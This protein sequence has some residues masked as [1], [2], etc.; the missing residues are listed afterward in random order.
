MNLPSCPDPELLATCAEGRLH[1]DERENVLRHI[2]SCHDCHAVF[3]ETL[4]LLDEPTLA[5]VPE[6]RLA[7]EAPPPAATRPAPPENVIPY[8]PRRWRR[9]ATVALPLAAAAAL[10]V[11]VIQRAPRGGPES[12]RVAQASPSPEAVRSPTATPTTTGVSPSPGPVS[13]PAPV[14]RLLAE[15]DLD[16]D[17]LSEALGGPIGGLGFVSGGSRAGLSLRLGVATAQLLAAR[18]VGNHALERAL[19]EARERGLSQDASSHYERLERALRAGRLPEAAAI[20]PP[21]GNYD[22]RWFELGAGLEA[23]RLAAE[24]ERRAYF[25][26]P[27]TRRVLDDA[28]STLSAGAAVRQLAII[29]DTIRRDGEWS[30]AD[31][32]RLGGA[33]SSLLLVASR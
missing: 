20:L 24:L 17:A 4:R 13:L 9:A 28:H 27:A 15:R 10:V 29:D 23:C 7:P 6:R 14:V 1:G 32:R 2:T 5:K 16:R 21:A 26:D 25:D 31:W 30:D 11:A 19:I 8:D 12:P 3:V 18:H 22:A 33:F